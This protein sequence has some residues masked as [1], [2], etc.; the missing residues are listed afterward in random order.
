MT[1]WANGWKTASVTANSA[2]V[3]ASE[4]KRESGCFATIPKLRRV[5][6][7]AQVFAVVTSAT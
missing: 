6:P 1:A 4:R 7:E 5:T 2:T 3:S